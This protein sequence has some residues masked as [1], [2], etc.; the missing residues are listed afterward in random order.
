MLS[1]VMLGWSARFLRNVVTCLWRI[2]VS[3][4]F[5]RFIDL[6]AFTSGK[7]SGAMMPVAGFVSSSSMRSLRV[8]CQHSPSR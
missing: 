3:P 5:A 1:W 4:L 6:R 2:Q 8:H 7:S